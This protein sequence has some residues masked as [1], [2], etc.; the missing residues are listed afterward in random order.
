MMQ[1]RRTGTLGS[2]EEGA[3]FNRRLRW[4]C[5]KIQ[6]SAP[7]EA[8][9]ETTFMITALSGSTTEPTRRTPAVVAAEP[10]R[11]RN[12]P[13]WASSARPPRAIPAGAVAAM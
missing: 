11:R 7:K 13:G 4:P 3:K 8:E 12:G 1:K 5:W 2:I 9:I 10:T 6:T